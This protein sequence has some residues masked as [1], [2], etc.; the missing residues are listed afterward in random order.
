MSDG[1]GNANGVASVIDFIEVPLSGP[2]YDTV[3]NAK[4]TLEVRD[5]GTT[6]RTMVLR[7]WIDGN[8]V[9]TMVGWDAFT[10][11]LDGMRARMMRP[12]WDEALAQ[13]T[14]GSA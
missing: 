1:D 7:T 5:F 10:D 2:I 12:D 14:G 11:A 8:V 9:T 6:E 13:L 3:D 4:L